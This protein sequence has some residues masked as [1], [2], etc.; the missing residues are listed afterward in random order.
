M[1]IWNKIDDVI[2]GGNRWKRYIE[3]AMMKTIITTKIRY[4][5]PSVSGGLPGPNLLYTPEFPIFHGILRI[6]DMHLDM[7][8]EF[9]GV[10]LQQLPSMLVL[11]TWH[12]E[13]K[14]AHKLAWAGI[15]QAG[16]SL[17]TSTFFLARL[18]PIF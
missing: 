8:G 6:K 2:F 13:K 5:I 17:V 4:L 1:W 16:S 9:F 7:R 14:V 11:V 15:S 12:P 3:H 18:T 10:G